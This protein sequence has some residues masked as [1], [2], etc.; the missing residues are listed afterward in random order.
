MAML[1]PHFF[2]RSIKYWVIM[3][4]QQIGPGIF[5][6]QNKLWIFCAFYENENVFKWKVSHLNNL[7][8]LCL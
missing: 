4:N 7:E 5:F 3:Q 6:L 1:P 2:Q 8:S